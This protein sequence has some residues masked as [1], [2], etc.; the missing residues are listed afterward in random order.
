MEKTEF[1]KSFRE[2]VSAICPEYGLVAID[3]IVAQACLESNYGASKLSSHYNNYWGMKCGSSY[4]GKSVNMKTQEEYEAGTKTTIKSNFR[5]YDSVED[6]IKGYCEFITGMKRYKN[7]LGV[8]D[9]NQY[10]ETIKADGWATDSAYISKVKSVLE[11]VL[12]SSKAEETTAPTPTPA[13]VEPVK[14]TASSATVERAQKA[15][16]MFIGSNLTV[17]GIRGANTNKALAKALQ[18]ALNR[19]YGANLA[20]D[21][22][23][24]ELTRKAY[25][26]KTVKKGAQSW[27]VS[28][29]EISL[30]LTGNYTN[31][32]EF[33]GVFGSGVDTAVRAF[34]E[35]NGLT[36]DGVVGKNTINKIIEVLGL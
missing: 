20:I 16:N 15:I 35:N 13:P 32:I 14:P 23:I 28:W 9:S 27:L 29:L 11:V 3:A 6:G 33:A 1:I 12:A 10:I 17:D 21:G 26:K 24:G 30:L 22:A 4:K 2:K 8:T 5:A 25:E 36:V 31:T 19:D 7:L 18:Y 34:Q